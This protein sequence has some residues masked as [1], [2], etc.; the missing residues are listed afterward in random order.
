MCYG[1]LLLWEP[2]QGLVPDGAVRGGCAADGTP[3]YVGRVHVDDTC[4]CGETTAPLDGVVIVVDGLL[5]TVGPPFELLTCQLHQLALSQR[6]LCWRPVEEQGPLP[7]QAV[8]A[9]AHAFCCCPAEVRTPLSPSI[10]PQL[11]IARSRQGKAI[12]SGCW[13][14]LG[15]WQVPHCPAHH[16]VAY[17]VL[18]VCSATNAVAPGEEAAVVGESWDWPVLCSRTPGDQCWTVVQHDGLEHLSLHVQRH[19]S[20]WLTVLD[21]HLVG[22]CGRYRIISIQE[23]YYVIARAPNLPSIV[24]AVRFI[25]TQFNCRQSL[26]EYCK[27]GGWPPTTRRSLG[28]PSMDW[29]ELQDLPPSKSSSVGLSRNVSQESPTTFNQNLTEATL[30]VADLLWT[31]QDG[32]PPPCQDSESRDPSGSEQPSTLV[33]EIAPPRETSD[34][35]ATETPWRKCLR[36]DGAIYYWNVETDAVQWSPPGG[37]AGIPDVIQYDWEVVR[38][39][40]RKKDVLG[41]GGGGTVY[42]GALVPGG[43]EVAVKVITVSEGRKQ[44]DKFEFQREIDVVT[45]VQHPNVAPILGYAVDTVGYRAALIGPMYEGSLQDRLAD[46][47]LRWQDRIA[48]LLD[49]ANGLRALHEAPTPIIHRDVKPGNVLLRGTHAVVCDFGLALL[50]PELLEKSSAVASVRAGTPGFMAPEALLWRKVGPFT[51]AYGFGVTALLVFSGA[52]TPEDPRHD[53]VTRIPWLLLPNPFHFPPDVCSALLTLA[54]RC[55][56]DEHHYAQRPSMGD[57]VTHLRPLARDLRNDPG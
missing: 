29:E 31:H 24:S 11:A 36:G 25:R 19:L 54:S 47:S 7:S 3:L 51:D 35:A 41:G 56:A 46:P 53:H 38:Q 4:L 14:Q 5:R 17:Q 34:R 57:L 44:V 42:R 33:V 23:P 27:A 49:I 37:L 30:A 55:V 22:A 43:P 12:H 50:S 52:T 13:Q 16:G 2:F 9:L 15:G 8:D 21:S 45:R 48:I 10:S 1:E 39:V 6:R 26:L 28:C 20:T 18:C 40:R 32:L